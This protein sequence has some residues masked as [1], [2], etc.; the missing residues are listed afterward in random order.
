MANRK[1]NLSINNRDTKNQ[2]MFN[3]RLN[4]SQRAN[5]A[6]YDPAKAKSQNFKVAQRADKA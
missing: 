3:I 2:A 5:R 6:E 1:T 4:L